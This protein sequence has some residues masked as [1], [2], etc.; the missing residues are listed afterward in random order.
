MT[1]KTR[2][3]GTRGLYELNALLVVLAV[4]VSGTYL[5]V[6]SYATTPPV[7]VSTA[8]DQGALKGATT[9]L[10]DSSTSDGNYVQFGANAGPR[11]ANG[12]L[13]SPS[14]VW[15][16]P[17]G[18]NPTLASNNTSLIAAFSDTSVCGSNCL[19]P[20]YDYTPAI[21]VANNS[22]PLVT[23]VVDYPTC[24]A[25]TVQVPIPAGAVPDPSLEGH[26]VIFAK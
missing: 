25:K 5:V 9:I 4:A 24:N 3:G 19:H 14:S 12:P 18:S 20:Q 11:T 23:V 10:P 21:W 7:T 17:I 1:N 22:T 16:T 2:F 13:F 15:D 6:G 8:A 26:M